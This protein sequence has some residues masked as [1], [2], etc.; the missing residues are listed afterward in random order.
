MLGLFGKWLHA[1]DTQFMKGWQLFSQ[2]LFRLNIT[3]IQISGGERGK[4]LINIRPA[5]FNNE[6]NNELNNEPITRG[7]SLSLSFSVFV[8]VSGRRMSFCK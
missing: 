6:L 2:I 3:D 8:H 1:L 4:G 7:F 5:G